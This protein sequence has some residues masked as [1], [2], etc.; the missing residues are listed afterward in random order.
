MGPWFD[1]GTQ[2]QKAES[3]CCPAQTTSQ[4]WETYA[5]MEK[6][7]ICTKVTS[8]SPSNHQ[9]LFLHTCIQNKEIRYTK[10][11]YRKGHSTETWQ[12]NG[13]LKTFYGAHLLFRV[14]YRESV[15]LYGFRTSIPAQ[16]AFSYFD[17][18][19]WNSG[20]QRIF[21]AWG[22]PLI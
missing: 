5:E 16:C 19:L 20:V 11:P 22:Q 9:F 4:P 17:P 21:D 15:Q 8:P 13:C 12:V 2:R 3:A 18:S 1:L 10:V 14:W 6:L 7:C